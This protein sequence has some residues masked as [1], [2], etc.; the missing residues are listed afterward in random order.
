METDRTRLRNSTKHLV[1]EILTARANKDFVTVAA[2][3]ELLEAQCQVEVF[4]RY[5]D[6]LPTAALAQVTTDPRA[7]LSLYEK[8]LELNRSRPDSKSYEWQSDLALRLI[9]IGEAE[10][11]RQ[12]LADSIAEADVAG[13]VS[14]SKW[15]AAQLS[16]MEIRR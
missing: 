13:D 6:P 5:P 2:L 10:R 16:S 3:I 1:T 15:L 8:A 12:M 14:A 7:A 11:A 4:E 9:A